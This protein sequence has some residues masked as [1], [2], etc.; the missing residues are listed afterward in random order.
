MDQQDGL[1][2]LERLRAPGVG[3]GAI[4]MAIVAAFLAGMLTSSLLPDR[5]TALSSQVGGP[6][7]DLAAPALP[8]GPPVQDVAT[9]VRV[10]RIVAAPAPPFRPLI[11]DQ[12]TPSLVERM[13]A[14]P[15]PPFRPLIDDQ[16]SPSRIGG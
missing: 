2:R 16:G 3:T 6:V 12:G 15:A 7:A 5:P 9:P 8:E 1:P 13:F 10:E 14:E 4:G 11:D